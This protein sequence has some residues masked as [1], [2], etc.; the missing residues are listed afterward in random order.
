MEEVEKLIQER[1]VI[2]ATD[3]KPIKNG[4]DIMHERHGEI[5]KEKE[6]KIWA[7]QN[8]LRIDQ[9]EKDKLREEVNSVNA[10]N[11]QQLITIHELSQAN[12]CN[13]RQIGWLSTQLGTAKSRCSSLEKDIEEL[14]LK[15]KIAVSALM[16][17]AKK[18]EEE[19]PVLKKRRLRNGM[20]S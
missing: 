12:L 17:T 18:L 1:G 8:Q 10:M 16:S 14:K 7:L 3:L 2:F 5:L 19:K 6:D 13:Y 20:R 11:G 9:A 15:G 4:L